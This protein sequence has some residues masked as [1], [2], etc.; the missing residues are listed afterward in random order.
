MNQICTLC[1]YMYMFCFYKQCHIV[2]LQFLIWSYAY[3]RYDPF[4][5]MIFINPPSL[6]VRQ[7]HW[8]HFSL[9]SF[10]WDWLDIFDCMQ[11]PGSDS[12][13]FCN[14]L[15]LN[16]DFL[17]CQCCQCY[18]VRLTC[19]NTNHIT[20]SALYLRIQC[21]GHI[22]ID[23]F[24]LLRWML[25]WVEFNGDNFNR[26]GCGSQ[27]ISHCRIIFCCSMSRF[28]CMSGSLDILAHK[29]PQ[30]GKCCF[31]IHVLYMIYTNINI[32]KYKKCSALLGLTVRNHDLVWRVAHDIWLERLFNYQ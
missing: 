27:N 13:C 23:V 29:K 5:V 14:M 4:P 1:M 31:I 8:T 16:M 26:G 18:Y 30:N 7:T 21:I 12:E 17:H 22:C 24:R 25:S 11:N 15:A 32:Y 28:T 3:F 10:L 20:S 6:G 9:R 19:T 2:L